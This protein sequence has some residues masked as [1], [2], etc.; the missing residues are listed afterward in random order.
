MGF[1]F[2][3]EFWEADYNRSFERSKSK[4]ASFRIRLAPAWLLLHFHSSHG[5]PLPPKF[6][7]R[8]LPMLAETSTLPPG[9]S[10]I[11]DEVQQRLD[12]AI[13]LADAR[14]A[15]MPHLAEATFGE[16]RRQEIAK[17]S[18]RLQR[19]HAYLE[20]PDQ[21][22]QSVDE[23]LQKEESSLRQHLSRS[24]SLRQKLAERTA[25]AIG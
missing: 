22:V 25:R 16:E 10:T 4:F 18:E 19:L 21:V 13:T 1:S 6:D 12:R 15:Q 5:I 11:L 20:G 8:R 3:Y 2:V 24:G 7:S 23:L 14:M 17:W 9:W